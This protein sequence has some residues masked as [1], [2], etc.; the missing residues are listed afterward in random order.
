MISMRLAPAVLA[1][2]CVSPA[3]A[4]NQPE[5]AGIQT[6]YLLPMAS[7]LDQYLANQLTVNGVFQVVT[8]PGKADA[9][10]TDQI[11]PAFEMQLEELYPPEPEPEPAKADSADKESAERDAEAEAAAAEA[12]QTREAKRPIVSSFRRGKGNVFLVD[13]RTRH[14]VWSTYL[15]PKN[16]SSKQ[17]NKAA[18]KIVAALQ[19]AVSGQP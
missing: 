9:I 17:L 2:L 10:F 7:G 18:A 1:L 11:G 12:K 6:V 8:D 4:A 15:P 3:P 13:L 14:V 5:L 16:Y 19:Q